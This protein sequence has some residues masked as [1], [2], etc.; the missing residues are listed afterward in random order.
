MLLLTIILADNLPSIHMKTHC[1]VPS[2]IMLVDVLNRILLA[3]LV[4]II[5]V[6]AMVAAILT[7]AA[8]QSCKLVQHAS[9]GLMLVVLSKDVEVNSGYHHVGVKDINGLKIAHLNVQSVRNN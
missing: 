3:D 4:E 2:R 6:L 5:N 1:F 9:L 7:T 8:C